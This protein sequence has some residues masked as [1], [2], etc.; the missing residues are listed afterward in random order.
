[1]RDAHVDG[2]SLPTFSRANEFL[3]ASEPVLEFDEGV[4]PALISQGKFSEAE[5]RRA[6]DKK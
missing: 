1:L 5:Q 4:I 6:T 2:K 3:I